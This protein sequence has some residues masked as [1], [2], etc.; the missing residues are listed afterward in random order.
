MTISRQVLKYILCMSLV[1]CFVGSLSA[2][3][4]L[5]NNVNDH[6]FTSQEGLI[7]RTSG[8]WNL[9]GILIDIDGDATGVG[10]HNWTWAESQEWCS[11][12]GTENEPYVIEN[13]TINANTGETA[14]KIVDSDVFF[15]INNCTLKGSS[16]ERGI[17]LDNVIHGEIKGCQI[18]HFSFGITYNYVNETRMIDNYIH[19]NSVEGCYIMRS[20]FNQFT[21]NNITNHL[22]AGLAPAMY[23]GGTSCYNNFT[24]NSMTN[25]KRGIYIV[26]QS[27]SN[28]FLNNDI[29]E[30]TQTGIEAALVDYNVFYDNV[31]TDNSFHGI[32][33]NYDSS[34]NHIE[35]NIFVDNGGSGVSMMNNASDNEIEENQFD[36]NGYGVYIYS[37]STKTED[38]VIINN[39]ILNS[40]SHGVYFWGNGKNVSSNMI[41]GNLIQ[42]SVSS[43]IH[44][45]DQVSDNGIIGNSIRNNQRGIN[46]DHGVK[47]VVF[48][49]LIKDNT[50]LGVYTNRTSL[51]ND[52]NWIFN[53][54]FMGNAIHAMDESL[55][56][57][58]NNTEIGN[59]WDNYT[60]TDTDFNGIGDQ[61]HVFNGGIDY[62]P[63]YNPAPQITIISPNNDTQVG[64][65]APS[66]TI[67]VIA[68][69][70]DT[71]WYVI[72]G[73]SNIF[74]IT[75]NGTIDTAFWQSIWDDFSD[76]DLV[77]ITFYMND[78]LGRIATN[79]VQLIIDKSPPPGIPGFE[80]FTL[81]L[82]IL[83]SIILIAIRTRKKQ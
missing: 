46:I 4:N 70:T 26:D 10:A 66:F 42:G 44:F 5:V 14:I 58:W 3:L 77:I 7:I 53:N 30:N 1:L 15:S 17:R 83:A 29:L 75:S 21:L 69:D 2:T 80:V 34:H 27:N 32:L 9:T 57:L 28:N 45:R 65:D 20:Y 33:L 74:E 16:A 40:D 25:N 39:D 31:I 11:G 50:E 60:G 81:S 22:G 38:N 51:A 56:N 19:D 48:N 79:S 13:V 36:S 8:F 43:G 73:Y 18:S 76:D 35:S 68:S 52:E 78:T 82:M 59:F 71:I 49:N 6:D 62:L 12:L 47:N 72:S 63:I 23:V 67:L 41:V 55:N 64:Q 61:P 54:T 24:K 37:I